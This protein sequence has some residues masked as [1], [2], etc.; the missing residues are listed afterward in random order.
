MRHALHTFTIMRIAE[1]KHITVKGFRLA[2]S[3]REYLG[4]HRWLYRSKTKCGVLY[5][6]PGSNL[7]TKSGCQRCESRCLRG[8]RERPTSFGYWFL[9]CQTSENNLAIELCVNWQGGG[10][11]KKT[12]NLAYGLFPFSLTRNTNKEFTNKILMKR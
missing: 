6:K 2:S 4:N 12:I 5:R 7:R 3:R 8:N 1:D 10:K 11:V 9:A